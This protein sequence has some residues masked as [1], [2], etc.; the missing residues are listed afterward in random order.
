MWLA[1]TTEIGG[2]GVV[3]EVTITATTG[4]TTTMATGTSVETTSTTDS[5]TTQREREGNEDPSG[6]TTVRGL[7]ESVRESIETLEYEKKGRRN[8]DMTFNVKQLQMQCHFL[9]KMMII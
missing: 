5:T 9:Q 7:N 3:E 1:F 8:Y 6:T 4:T 2:D